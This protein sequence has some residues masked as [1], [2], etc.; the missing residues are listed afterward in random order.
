MSTYTIT[1]LHKLA[2][3]SYSSSRAHFISEGA[4]PLIVGDAASG[5]EENLHAVLWD[6]N[7]NRMI[8]LQG[9]SNWQWPD[10]ANPSSLALSVNQNGDVAGSTVKPF[11][12]PQGRGWYCAYDRNSG[13]ASGMVVLPNPAGPSHVS[14]Y[15]SLG[16]GVSVDGG[17]IVGHLESKIGWFNKLFTSHRAVWWGHQSGAEISDPTF[18]PTFGLP[19]SKATAINVNGIIVGRAGVDP[20]G[21]NFHACKWNPYFFESYPGGIKKIYGYTTPEEL[22]P[23]RHVTEVKAKRWRQDAQSYAWAISSSAITVGASGNDIDN[24]NDLYAC[25]WRAGSNIAELLFKNTLS[26]AY[27]VNKA[28]QIVGLSWPN[29]QTTP[30]GT[31]L[32]DPSN[33]DW[34]AFLY[35]DPSGGSEPVKLIDLLDVNDAKSKDWVYLSAARS[36]ND[37]GEIVGVGLNKDGKPS[38]FVMTPKP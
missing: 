38:A 5:P 36:V 4:N 35:P 16:R 13:H 9:G 30:D 10:S 11:D 8:D 33:G 18:L 29:A 32:G 24:S 20:M 27:G 34:V 15:A 26:I 31:D 25:V 22:L 14:Y 23:A 2:G 3:N 28:G 19:G 6:R 7:K 21:V 37:A 17:V 12:D 1:N